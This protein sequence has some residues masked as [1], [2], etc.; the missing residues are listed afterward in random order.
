MTYGGGCP[1]VTPR[2][3]E[4]KPLLQSTG[5]CLCILISISIINQLLCQD[6]TRPKMVAI[7]LGANGILLTAKEKSPE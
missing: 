4:G 3:M 1:N 2:G 6:K 5:A 7:I